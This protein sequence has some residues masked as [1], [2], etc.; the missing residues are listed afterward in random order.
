MKEDGSAEKKNYYFINLIML[1]YVMDRANINELISF[2]YELLMKLKRNEME[3]EPNRW[4]KSLRSG[5][6]KAMV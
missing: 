3:S 6:G 2:N 4:Q 5:G 1:E